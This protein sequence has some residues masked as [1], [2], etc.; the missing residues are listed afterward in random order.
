MREH[1]HCETIAFDQIFRIYRP[2][3]FSLHRS[4]SSEAATAEFKL[5]KL[6]DLS[7]QTIF[8]IAPSKQAY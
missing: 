1:R 8:A 6:I 4:G 2:L 7:C 5:G 3:A